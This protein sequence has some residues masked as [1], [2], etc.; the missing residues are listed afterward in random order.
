MSKRITAQQQLEQ[1]RDACSEAARLTSAGAQAMQEAAQ[2]EQLARTCM[3]AL[4]HVPLLTRGAA[5]RLHEARRALR[6]Q[7]RSQCVAAQKQ[8]AKHCSEAAQL[9]H[10]AYQQAQGAEAYAS[11]AEREL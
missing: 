4:E 2:A 7:L 3:L 1:G 9:M 5:L 10:E 8:A 11:Q 6:A